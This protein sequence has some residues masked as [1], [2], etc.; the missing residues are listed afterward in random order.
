MGTGDVGDGAGEAPGEAPI[1][2]QS[3]G[4]SSVATFGKFQDPIMKWVGPDS[5]GPAAEGPE[6]PG[7]LV[8][9]STGAGEGKEDPTEIGVTRAGSSLDTS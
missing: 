2:D 5:W 3:G 7:L 9:M 4:S 8:S 6:G 1:G